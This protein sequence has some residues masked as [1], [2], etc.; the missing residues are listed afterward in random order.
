MP[1]GM[2]LDELALQILIM[3]GSKAEGR[4]APP[5]QLGV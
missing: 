5:D 3:A 4:A 1:E 2:P